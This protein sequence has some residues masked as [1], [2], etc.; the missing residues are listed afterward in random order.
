[1]A[2][3]KTTTGEIVI[4]RPELHPKRE[5]PLVVTPA[6]GAWKNKEQERY[7]QFLNAYY[8]QNPEKF[9]Q[10]WEDFTPA[11]GKTVKGL[12]TRLEEIGNDPA[13]FHEYNGNTELAGG[14]MVKNSLIES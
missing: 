13:K 5:L 10:K 4:T 2:K 8:Y 11:G 14:V 12:K 3:E 1:M 7:A 6:D 9:E